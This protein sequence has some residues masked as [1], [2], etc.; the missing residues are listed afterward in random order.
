MFKKKLEKEPVSN[1]M[2]PL[3]NADEEL[4]EA[5]GKS[6]K[7]KKRKVIRR[8]LILVILLAVV[9]IV[10]V[11]ILQRK[12][13]SQFASS[14]AEVLSAQAERGTVSTVVSGSGVL[15]NVDTEVISVPSGV[16][17]TKVLVEFG[18][19]VQEGDLLAV[20]DMATVRTAMSQLQTEIEDLDDRITAAEGDTVSSYL[21]AGVP[22]RVKALHAGVDTPVE[23]AM[24]EYGS[25]AEIS[26]DGFMA[27]DLETDALTEG[28]KVT[29]ILSGGTEE[30]GTVESVVGTKATVLV[31]DNGPESDE[32]VTVVSEE[33][34]LFRHR[35]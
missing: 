8:V 22:G 23:D 12:V 35:Q 18:D 21:S 15:V 2:A 10:G 30:E 27:V 25:L 5:L 28:E 26:L 32:E 14:G 20:A 31:T 1:G 7:A 33:G 6:K 3:N 9:L 24:V 11:G 19:S 29:V 34:S 13:R 4:F 16:E 17:I